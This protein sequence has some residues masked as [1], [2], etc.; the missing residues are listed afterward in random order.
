MKI[1][2]SDGSQV[3]LSDINLLS[4]FCIGK[5]VVAFETHLIKNIPL[6]EQ[7]VQLSE[8]FSRRAYWNKE[9]DLRDLLNEVH[10][11]NLP[12]VTFTDTGFDGGTNW[13]LIVS[14]HNTKLNIEHEETRRKAVQGPPSAPVKESSYLYVVSSPNF[15]SRVIFPSIQAAREFISTLPDKACTSYGLFGGTLPARSSVKIFQI[16]AQEVL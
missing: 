3:T 12:Y 4:K 15:S 9:Y 10:D 11:R 7:V 13:D 6:T 14:F 1:L 8:L 16:P 2:F 5:S